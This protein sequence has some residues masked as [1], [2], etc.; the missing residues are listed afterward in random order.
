MEDIPMTTTNTDANDPDKVFETNSDN[1][2]SD[3]NQAPETSSNFF[4]NLAGYN[5]IES[6]TLGGLIDDLYLSLLSTKE[7]VT[8]NS[9]RGIVSNKYYLQA[10]KLQGLISV[11]HPPPLFVIMLSDLNPKLKQALKDIDEET[12]NYVL[13]QAIGRIFENINPR[14]YPLSIARRL[15][16]RLDPQHRV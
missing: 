9:G 4:R 12:K 1:A 15:R 6:F 5:E 14:L 16:W 13:N 2:A 7:T 10:W 3:S 11:G 8:D